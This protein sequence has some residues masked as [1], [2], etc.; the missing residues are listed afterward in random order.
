MTHLQR[1]A[2]ANVIGSGPNGLAAAITLARAGLDVSVYEA[3]NVPGGAARTLELTLPGFLHDFG[4]AVHPMAVVSPFFQSVSIERRGVKWIHSPAPLAHPL[5]NGDAVLLHRYL[6][7]QQTELGRDGQ[8]WRDLFGPLV[9]HWDA[10]A[11]DTLQPMAHVPKHPIILSK[12]GAKAFMPAAWLARSQFRTPRARALFAGIAAHSF[13]SLRAPISSAV[14]LMLGAVGHVAGWPIPEG[15]AQSITNALVAEFES[16][17]G[18]LN[19]SH[20]VLGI[21]ELPAAELAMCDLSPRQLLQ[22]AGERLSPAYQKSLALFR[23]GPGSFKVDY[24]LSD[25]IPWRAIQCRSAATVH[26]GGTFEEI[27]ASESAMSQGRI[28]EK[29]FVLVAQPSLFDSSRSPDLKHV[30]WA[31]CHVPNGC[32]VD[33]TNAIEQQIE[34]F[35]PGFRDCILA[36]SVMTPARLESMDANLVGGDISGGGMDMLQFLLRPT[37]RYY[38]TSARNIFLCSS[39]TPPGGG[40]H[41]MCGYNAAC[42][43]LK[44]RT[45]V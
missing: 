5:D 1:G 29:P 14:G 27:A 24:A 43:A 25:P 8:I 37:W 3:E 12:F 13:L 33:M 9:R 19:L 18:R 32:P 35:A 16:L 7:D 39:S 34:R 6:I 15:G 36:R 38:S 26:V 10:L 2:R 21:Q 42:Q 11:E 4:S 40:V 23:P 22:L 41:G 20:R 31:Y 44:G 45:I 28:A 17:G 30:A